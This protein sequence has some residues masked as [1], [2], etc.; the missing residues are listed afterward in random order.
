VKAA[1]EER[2]RTT[3]PRARNITLPQPRESAFSERESGATSP[4]KC[5]FCAV[6]PERG[7]HAASTSLGIDTWK[8]HE[9]RAP[10]SVLEKKSSPKL[11]IKRIL[12]P[13]DFSAP[14]LKALEYALPFAEQFGATLCLVHVVE[15]AS[16]VQDLRNLPLAVTDEEAASG[17]KAKLIAL[18]R[19]ETGPL[20]PVKPQVRIGKPFLEIA[21]AAK[22]LN[23]DLIII[24]T[25]GFTG[26]KHTILGSTAELVVRYA[27]CPV[28][29]VRQRKHGC[30]AVSTS[31]KNAPGAS[32]DFPLP[33]TGRG[34]KG[35]GWE[36]SE[37]PSTGTNGRQSVTSA[38]ALA[39]PYSQTTPQSAFPMNLSLNVRP[40]G[41]R[42]RPS[43]SPRPS[44]Q[45]RGRIV[46]HSS[47]YPRRLVDPKT[48]MRVSL[49]PRER[50][51]VR[52]KETI[53]STTGSL[54]SLKKE[55]E[56]NR[57]PE[58]IASVP[59]KTSRNRKREFTDSNKTLNRKQNL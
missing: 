52:G 33:S 11:K 28:L 29:V 12:V 40:L 50:V 41:T 46:L 53:T 37:Q 3:R 48:G 25:H 19:K 36:G 44:P 2:T 20:I 21:N 17:A 1:I 23:A 16:F 57:A 24:A 51:G 34:I 54:F 7:I 30:V 5:S 4:N 42:T 58:G 15:P 10:L 49:S 26:L 38:S 45:G 13:V 14:S 56:T 9:C 32:M 18:A 35:E 8:R 39:G 22:D 27:P 47:T 6:E 31:E 55:G 59:V 43:P